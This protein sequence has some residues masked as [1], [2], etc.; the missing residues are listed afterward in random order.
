MYGLLIL[1]GI[2]LGAV[3]PSLYTIIAIFLLPA[4]FILAISVVW[5]RFTSGKPIM[6]GYLLACLLLTI[7]E[8][9]HFLLHLRRMES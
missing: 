8:W 3:W 9:T 2:G 7:L 6:Q 1:F 5:P 4:F